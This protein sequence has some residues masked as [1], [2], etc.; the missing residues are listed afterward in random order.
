MRSSSAIAV[1]IAIAAVL[2][3]C[4]SIY[5]CEGR[6]MPAEMRGDRKRLAQHPPCSSPGPPSPPPAQTYTLH[7]PARDGARRPC[8]RPTLLCPLCSH[9][10]APFAAGSMRR[11][12]QGSV[13]SS[14]FAAWQRQPASPRVRGTWWCSPSSRTSARSQHWMLLLLKR[15][16]SL[17]LVVSWS[18][19]TTTRGQ[20]L[21]RICHRC[22]SR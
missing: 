10:A 21:Y 20:R 8:T 6:A 1:A 11:R 19:S 16:A 7:T 4:K 13:G 12:R 9:T 17:L 15:A 2:V 18:L 5:V 3:V 22:S 14:L